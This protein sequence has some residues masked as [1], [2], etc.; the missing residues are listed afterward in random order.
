MTETPAPTTESLTPKKKEVETPKLK[1]S[2]VKG[3][4]VK[5]V[6]GKKAKLTWKKVKGAVKY[7]IIYSMDKKMKKGKKKAISKKTEYK[8]KKL[9]KGKKY[10]VKIR[11]CQKDESGKVVYGSYSTIKKFKVK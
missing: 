5:A 4:V 1:V 3:V 9:K 7:E 10:Y 11:A 6:K 2:K 8:I